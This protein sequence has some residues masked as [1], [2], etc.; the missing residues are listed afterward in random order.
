MT[1]IAVELKDVTYV[2]PRTVSG[3]FD[4][5]LSINQGELVAIIGASGSGKTTLLKLIAGFVKP[6]KGHVLLNGRNVTGLPVRDREVGIVFQN[7]ALFPNMPVW[8]NVAYPLKIRSVSFKKRRYQAYEALEKMGLQGFETRHVQTLSGGQQQRVALARAL[9]FRPKALLLDEPLSAL[10]AN[11]RN[12]MR[13]EIR[14]LQQEQGI[15]TLHITHDQEEAMSISDR[16]AVMEN[17]RLVQVDSPQKLYDS[18]ITSS[19]AAFVGRANLLNARII[20]P[21]SVETCFGTLSTPSHGKQIGSKVLILIRPER[22]EPLPN[23]PSSSEENSKNV[24]PCN[25]LRDR[26][27]GSVRRYD[28]SINDYRLLGETN[29]RGDISKVFIDPSNIQI[30]ENDLQ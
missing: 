27:L 28:I 3:L 14:N 26:F 4:I 23:L 22:I 20:R 7:Y 25:L 17:G 18:P 9:I 11:L 29:V 12:E 30:L 24:F 8:E 15:A 10:D 13:D 1:S 5:D 16:V 2:Y 6:S 21:D 19:V